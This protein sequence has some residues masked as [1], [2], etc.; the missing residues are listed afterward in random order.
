MI[1]DN[2]QALIDAAR[3]AVA[4]GDAII[5]DAR[6]RYKLTR[7]ELARRRDVMAALAAGKPHVRG[8]VNEAAQ[9]T[10]ALERIGDAPEGLAVRIGEHLAA[11]KEHQAEATRELRTAGWLLGNPSFECL[12]LR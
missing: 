12:W 6:E 3:K 4:H 1:P 7:E 11:A 9:A 10:E 2:V 8:F 5:T